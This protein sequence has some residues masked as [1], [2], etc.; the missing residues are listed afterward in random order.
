[1]PSSLPPNPVLG[2]T[3][4]FPGGLPGEHAQAALD[5]PAAN[6]SPFREPLALRCSMP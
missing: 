4:A 6:R 2:G 3:E 5:A 1:M